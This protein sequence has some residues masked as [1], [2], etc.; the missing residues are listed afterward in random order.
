MA[1]HRCVASE[2]GARSLSQHPEA[3]PQ[4]MLAAWTA[5]AACAALKTLPSWAMLCV[6]VP[7]LQSSLCSSFL[8][9]S[10][11]KFHSVLRRH[12]PQICRTWPTSMW[13]LASCCTIPPAQPGLTAGKIPR[14]SREGP[15]E[16]FLDDACVMGDMGTSDSCRGASVQCAVCHRA[17]AKV[18]PALTGIPCAGQ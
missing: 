17:C 13:S 14:K 1:Q 5:R 2:T 16:V 9:I 4:R 10:L 3:N 7:H 15:E 12:R 18:K 11:A 8:S 6:P